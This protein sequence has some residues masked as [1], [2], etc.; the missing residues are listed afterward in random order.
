MRVLLGAVALLIGVD[1]FGVHRQA[2]GTTST[3]KLDM[4]VKNPPPND[5]TAGKALA[6]LG[7]AGGSLGLVIFFFHSLALNRLGLFQLPPP[8]RL[9]R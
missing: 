9:L 4:G 7:A 1:A 8:P 6:F 5:A 2:F 3:T